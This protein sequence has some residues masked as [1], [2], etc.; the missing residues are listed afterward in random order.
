MVHDHTVSATRTVSRVTYS[1]CQSRGRRTCFARSGTFL[2]PMSVLDPLCFRGHDSSAFAPRHP[3]PT[4]LFLRRRAHGAGEV[5]RPD[6]RA[7]PGRHGPAVRAPR[8]GDSRAA[9]PRTAPSDP[10]SDG[11][12]ATAAAATAA[13]S[14]P[15]GAAGRRAHDARARP[16]PVVPPPRADQRRIFGPRHCERLARVAVRAKHLPRR[17]QPVPPAAQELVGPRAIAHSQ[18]SA[19]MGLARATLAA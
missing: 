5:R 15:A 3:P 18:R 7:G 12:A 6:A 19:R 16:A 13:A 9:R 4:P 2:R 8:H 17:D 11:S 14:G 10:A 1:R